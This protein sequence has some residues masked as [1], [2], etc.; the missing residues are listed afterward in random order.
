MPI[1]DLKAGDTDP[2]IRARLLDGL[3]KP[4]P[5]TSSDDVLFRMVS[6]DQGLAP[7]LEGDAVIL[8]AD[9]AEVEYQWADGDTDIAGTYRAEFFVE[10]AS[11]QEQTVPNGGYID[12][13]IRPRAV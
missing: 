10:W 7:D 8:D 4:L 6:V 3:K 11:G 9:R 13:V 12:V 5:L 1:F 2:P